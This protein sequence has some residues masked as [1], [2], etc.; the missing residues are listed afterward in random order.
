MY[1]SSPDVRGPAV[2]H[3]RHSGLVL[4]SACQGYVGHRV[5]PLPRRLQRRACNLQTPTH[6][7]GSAS[8]KEGLVPKSCVPCWLVDKYF[9]RAEG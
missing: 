1:P 9:R 5:K 3:N 8:W 7:A 4:L 6:G 2:S